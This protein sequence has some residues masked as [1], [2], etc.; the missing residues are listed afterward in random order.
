MW[1]DDLATAWAK[2]CDAEA[3]AMLD[4]WDGRM[5]R[6]ADLNARIGRDQRTVVHW[7]CAKGAVGAVRALMASGASLGVSD[8]RSVTALMLAAGS[9][10][11]DVLDM[12]LV[13]GQ[14]GD[15]GAL[16][17]DG[18]AAV[19]H[20]AESGSSACVGRLVEAG[21]DP[22]ATGRNGDTV[23]MLAA[24]SG[25]AATVKAVLLTGRSGDVDA[26]EADQPTAL[27][28][29]AK[30]GSAEAMRVL[31]AAGADIETLA[32][33]GM[34]LLMW[35]ARSGSHEAVETVLSSGKA[36]DI[37]ATDGNDITAL[38]WAVEGGSPA[39]VRRLLAEGADPS[40]IG[41]EGMTVFTM[42]T[43]N[44]ASEEVVDV[45]LS[46]ERCG[47]VNAAD[48]SGETAL[49]HAASAG[50]AGAVRR[51][52]KAGADPRL[53]SEAGET[54]LM[55]AAGSGS[56]EALVEAI[57]A[58]GGAGDINA[59]NASG[60]TA[61]HN[62]AFHWTPVAVR[63]LL[64]AGADPG[65]A[66]SAG[67]TI[68]MQAS[69]SGMLDTL[70]AVL[71]SGK[72]GDINAPDAQGRTA[73]QRAAGQEL[74]AAVKRLLA[75]GADASLADRHGQTALMYAAREHQLGAVDALLSAATAGPIDAWSTGG[76]HPATALSMAA[77]HRGPLSSYGT[78]LDW[79]AVWRLLAGGADLSSLDTCMCRDDG[80]CFRSVAIAE[81]VRSQR[82]WARRRRL[83]VWRS[84][85]ME[86]RLE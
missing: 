29:A 8:L 39:V 67:V 85:A 13:S 18:R 56:E 15:V 27:S 54:V 79:R 14:C 52:L 38:H 49:H 2:G 16:D 81:V 64:A 41:Y 57:L 78:R 4:G 5:L 51:L 48:A 71:E 53:C 43:E 24:S 69:G 10:S 75:A 45:L 66:D 33:G 37:N 86:V 61:L 19:H 34:T 46:S 35:A 55:A 21:A 11:M 82:L 40:I 84:T 3:L 68:L 76:P 63:R 26:W 25:D 17:E 31:L 12:L 23:L 58:T 77:L 70:N 59:Q 74:A 36:G 62:A 20:A 6:G 28:C 50:A 32:N 73:L 9:G 65:L 1:V 42:L 7:A 44:G 80:L 22:G 72:C 83:V 60:R 47:D 30:K